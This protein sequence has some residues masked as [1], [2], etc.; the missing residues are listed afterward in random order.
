MRLML[1]FSALLL[2]LLS[3]TLAP[4]AL[5]EGNKGVVDKAAFEANVT[6]MLEQRGFTV[7]N[8]KVGMEPAIVAEKGSCR[9][10]IGLV[11][12]FGIGVHG[13]ELEAQDIGPL[14]FAYDGHRSAE[15]PRIWPVISYRLARLS[16][17]VGLDP[18]FEPILALARTS[19]CKGDPIPF[20][21][22][23]LKMRGAA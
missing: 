17:G 21:T 18:D 7:R 5:I 14:T 1:R 8:R 20:E 22:I 23:E 6:D 9:Q 10:L 3:V 4:K 12:T 16:H 19:G 15:F 13:M 11:D 2:V